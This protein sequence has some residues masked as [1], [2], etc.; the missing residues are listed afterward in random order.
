MRD[1]AV[2]YHYI[3]AVRREPYRIGTFDCCTFCAAAVNV[4]TGK[5]LMQGIPSYSTESEMQAL[6]QQYGGSLSALA[7]HFLQCEPK[8]PVCA[9][10][11]DIV[12]TRSRHG[13]SLGVCL[14]NAIAC[15][16]DSGIC[17]LPM[18]EALTSF[19]VN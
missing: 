6:I 18:S 15:V 12:L 17:Y 9:R 2:L 4:V 7:C 19:E 13:E 10:I 14:G 16:S 5:D 8:G 11:G 1:I 3:A